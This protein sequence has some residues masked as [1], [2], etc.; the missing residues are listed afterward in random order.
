MRVHT[1]RLWS[2]MLEVIILLLLGAEASNALLSELPPELLSVFSVDFANFLRVINYLLGLFL[3][4]ASSDEVYHVGHVVIETLRGCSFFT[5]FLIRP[6]GVHLNFVPVRVQLFSQ[7]REHF[8]QGFFVQVHVRYLP[9]QRRFT[10][11]A[12]CKNQY[13]RIAKVSG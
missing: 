2:A 4:V 9:V 5:V 13:L 8:L 11:I 6:H 12:L 1:F 3:R 7:V 10:N